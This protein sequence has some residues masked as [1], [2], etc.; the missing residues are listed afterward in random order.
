MSTTSVAVNL[1]YSAI[2]RAMR[3]VPKVKFFAQREIIGEGFFGWVFADGPSHVIKASFDRGFREMM[4]DPDRPQSLH[5]PQLKFDYGSIEMP[6]TGMLLHVVSC[7]RLGPIEPLSP[8]WEVARDFNQALDEAWAK[9]APSLNAI[10]RMRVLSKKF[11]ALDDAAEHL[12]IK[13]CLRD[14]HS[15]ADRHGLALSPYFTSH[16]ENLMARGADL[17]FVN[18]LYD[19]SIHCLPAWMFGHI[20]GVYEATNRSGSSSA[21]ARIMLDEDAFRDETGGAL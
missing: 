5:L 17:V 11:D 3:E 9:E 10:E 7:E 6:G 16:Q 20:H 18:P 2:R 15:F 12:S 8:S 4:V 19:P 13:H 21:R 14:M 1:E